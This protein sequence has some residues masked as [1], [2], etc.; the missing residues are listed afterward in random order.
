[1]AAF[2]CS[3]WKGDEG[4]RTGIDEPLAIRVVHFEIGHIVREQ[5]EHFTLAVEAGPSKHPAGGNASPWGQLVQN[6]IQKLRGYGHATLVK[7]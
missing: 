2:F 1:M 7:G 5:A 6:K 3:V 4:R